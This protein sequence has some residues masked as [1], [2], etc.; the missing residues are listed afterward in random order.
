MILKR[1]NTVMTVGVQRRDTYLM[2]VAVATK[3]RN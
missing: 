3:D 2:P 1:L